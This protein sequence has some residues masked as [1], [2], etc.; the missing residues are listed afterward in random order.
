MQYSV[1]LGISK[2]V[3]IKLNKIDTIKTRTSWKMGMLRYTILVAFVCLLRDLRRLLS[4]A[5]IL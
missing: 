3:K 5:S 1:Q 2:E 4:V